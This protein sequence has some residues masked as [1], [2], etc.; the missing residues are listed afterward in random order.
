MMNTKTIL[1]LTLLIIISACAPLEEENTPLMPMTQALP[2]TP[3][4][5]P[6][7]VKSEI[8]FVSNTEIQYLPTQT[9]LLSA[10]QTDIPLPQRPVWIAGIPHADGTAWAVSFEDGSL[11]AYFVNNNGYEEIAI[12][13]Q[14]FS[15]EMPLTIYSSN[16]ELFALAA[17]GA[18]AAPYSQPIFL[19]AASGK[20][21]YIASN[22]DLVI[23]E[24]D[25]E[26]RLSVNA[27]LDSR[28]LIDEHSRLLFLSSPTDR[29]THGVLG[30]DI[31]AT[32]ITL[33]ATKP[34]LKV[35]QTIAIPEPD[36]IEGIYPIWADLNNDGEREIIVTLSNAQDGARILAFREDGSLLAE[37]PAIGT[38]YRWRHQL[39]VAPFGEFE[40]PLLAVI[41]TPHIGGVIEYYRLNGNTLEI[42]KSISGFSTHSI[43]SRNL[44]TAQAGD[45]DSDGQVELL[46]PDQNQ[47]RLGIIG[48]DGE[49]AFWLDLQ[50]E[51][52][53]N[54]AAVE[55]AEK[56]EVVI[57]GGLSTNILRI[58]I[59]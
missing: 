38:G 24:N 47:T 52:V 57:A 12:T 1:L 55:V 8:D 21:A 16:G 42:V 4:T 5:S 32:G 23:S 27:L 49:P 35:L 13:P 41:R 11:S 17:P 3:I 25:Q 26:T 28:I 31:E 22:G 37:G 14:R 53:T 10:T 50:A 34:E 2:E 33:V 7:P 59:Q 30:D 18:D 15:P 20:I 39:V 44:F 43:G 46:L 45:F 56:G 54:L 36:V 58:W 48:V 51:L 6:L 40:E 29:Y 19:D 9:D